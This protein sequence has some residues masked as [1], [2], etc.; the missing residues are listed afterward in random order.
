MTKKLVVLLVVLTGLVFGSCATYSTVNGI[1]TPLGAYTSAKINAESKPIASYSVILGLITMG[2]EDFLSA[3][4]GKD[5]DIIDTSYFG[6]FT[7]VSAVP[8]R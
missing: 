1:R 3:V 7:K 2:Y 6:F 4:K 5:I 8:K